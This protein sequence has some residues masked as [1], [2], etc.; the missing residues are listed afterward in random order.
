MKS[1][2]SSQKTQTELTKLS[3]KGTVPKWLNG[4]L[5]RNGPALFETETVKFKH[6]FDGYGL[7]HGFNI[8]NGK[9]FYHS[10]FIQSEEYLKSQTAGKFLDI[11]WGTPVDPC[12]SIFQKLFVVFSATPSNTN[13]NIV[14]IGQKYFTISDILTMNE[15]DIDS[16][17]TLSTRNKANGAM[18][19]HPAFDK[20]GSV[21][22]I[23]SSFSPKNPVNKIVCFNRPLALI[24]KIV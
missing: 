14:K 3:V 4:K 15:V 6:W 21:W 18:A 19:A 10:K 20:D 22:N 24:Q 11:T 7:L 8:Q 1:Y 5:L 23:I 12:S 9:V 13:V 2:L 16:L 17:E